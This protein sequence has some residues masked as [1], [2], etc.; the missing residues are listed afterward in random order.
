MKKSKSKK[1]RDI[2]HG[3][4]IGICVLYTLQGTSIE[5]Y[6]TYIE[7]KK[8]RQS[9]IV[10]NKIRI[11]AEDIDKKGKKETLLIYSGNSYLLMLDDEGKPVV[12]SYEVQPVI[13][14]HKVKS[15]EIIIKE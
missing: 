7:P 9:Y 5:L 2:I 11:K 14:Y 1:I 3:V 4:S 6:K 8:I 12:K 13:K 15:L 10:P